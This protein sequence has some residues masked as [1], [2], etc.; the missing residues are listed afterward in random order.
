MVGGDWAGGYVLQLRDL[1]G[2]IADGGE[3][4]DMKAMAHEERAALLEEVRVPRARSWA[5]F[6]ALEVLSRLGSPAGKFSGGYAPQVVPP[7]L[8]ALVGIP[9]D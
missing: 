6:V 4:E 5:M 7:G 1:E 8:P 9:K 3:D 2:L